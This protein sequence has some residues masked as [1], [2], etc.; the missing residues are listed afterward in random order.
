VQETVLEP[1]YFRHACKMF[2]EQ[3]RIPTDTL[4]SIIEAGRLTPSSFGMEPTRLMVIGSD[5][6]K[7]KLRPH[8][9]NQVQITSASEVVIYLSKRDLRSTNPYVKEMFSRRGLPKEA[10]DKYLEVYANHLDHLS[11]EMLTAWSMKQAYLMASS[12]MNSAAMMQIDS[13]PIEGFIKKE[14]EDLLEIDTKEYEVALITTFGYRV[15]EQSKRIRL[16][17]DE[18]VRFR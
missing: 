16:S 3:R 1:L 5:E 2:D 6:L 18:I 17:R 13:C 15:N 10:L 7:V 14:V 8:C 12:M 11:D 9:W 4:E